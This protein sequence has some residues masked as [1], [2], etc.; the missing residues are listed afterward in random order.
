MKKYFTIHKND[1]G[2]E[3]YTDEYVKG[4][5]EKLERNKRCLLGIARAVGFTT[6]LDRVDCGAVVISQAD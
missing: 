6:P 2:S 5:E 3:A 1:I 4:L